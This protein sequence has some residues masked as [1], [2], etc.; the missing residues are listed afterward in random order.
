MDREPSLAEALGD[1]PSGPLDRYRKS[2]SFD[3]KKMKLFVEG[4]DVLKFKVRGSII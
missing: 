3:W 1:F 2:A 4:E